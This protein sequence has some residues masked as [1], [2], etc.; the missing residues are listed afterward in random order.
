MLFRSPNT[1]IVEVGDLVHLGT[2]GTNLNYRFDYIQ[3]DAIVTAVF[4]RSEEL[5]ILLKLDGKVVREYYTY[6]PQY[7]S[8]FVEEEFNEIE[9]IVTN[10]YGVPEEEFIN[11][12]FI[13]FPETYFAD[14]Y[15]NMQDQFVS[16]F[17]IDTNRFSGSF[18]STKEQWMVT[19]IAYDEG[20]TVRVNDEPVEI[21]KVNGG[22]IGFKIP[23]GSLEIEAEFFPNT[24]KIGSAISFVSLIV[25]FL[26]KTKHWL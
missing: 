21:E 3:R 13:E 17:K 4:P 24:L 14:W 23:S 10:L 2:F 26:I 15:S 8:V 18:V 22:F 9:F 6:E 20:W 16:D 25:L 1:N 5:R 7:S 19:S 12:A 11:D